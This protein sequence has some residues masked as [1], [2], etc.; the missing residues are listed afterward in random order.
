MHK[1]YN[2]LIQNQTWILIDPPPNCSIISA[3]WLF[4]HKCN[5]NGS[6]AY[7]VAHGF[8]QQ[9]VLDYSE[10]FFPIFKMTSLRLLLVLATLYN[11]HIHQMDV[12]MAFLN[13]VLKEEI[14]IL[15]SNGKKACRLLKSL[16]GLKQAP[17]LWYVY[18]IKCTTS[19]LLLIIWFICRRSYYYF[20]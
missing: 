4:R 7:F 1:E 19:H 6:L 12:I 16:Y 10:T 9:A 2:S 15:L 5:S 8:F 20:R 13:G 18:V 14:Y 11:Y 3:K 17:C